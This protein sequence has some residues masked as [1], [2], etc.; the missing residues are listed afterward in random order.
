MANR[1]RRRRPRRST[2]SRSS[3]SL[4]ASRSLSAVPGRPFHGISATPRWCSTSRAY[5]RCVGHS[6]A[7]RS[8]GVPRA[9]R[10]EHQA[11]RHPDLVVG[12]G[13]RHDA[14]RR[15]PFER[16]GRRGRDP[17]RLEHPDRVGV[18]GRVARR[19]GHD[20]HVELPSEFVGE[21]QWQAPEIVWQVDDQVS[22]PGGH[23]GP[24]DLDRVGEEVGVVVPAVGEL[25]GHRPAHPDRLAAA[26]R[27]VGQGCR[28][29]VAGEAQLTV[30][31]AERDHGRR[32]RRHRV[33]RTRIGGE[34]VGHRQI[35]HRRRHRDAVGRGE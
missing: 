30:Q 4:G 35:D 21:R 24:D 27:V 14:N 16:G 11:R 20:A 29:V 6:T 25:A 19:G 32:M 22:Q 1:S 2:S 10:V 33:E 28:G 34:C 12:V 8:N 5:G 18:G 7:T 13:G 17:Q 9:G 26:S 31:L 15:A 23:S 3:T